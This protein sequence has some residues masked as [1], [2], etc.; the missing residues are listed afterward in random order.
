MW[1]HSARVL[2]K[3]FRSSLQNHGFVGDHS[4]LCISLWLICCK[5]FQHFLGG[6]IRKEQ[7]TFA[8]QML[9]GGSLFQ[10]RVPWPKGGGSACIRLLDLCP[11]R[12][13]RPCSFPRRICVDDYQ[14][15]KS[16]LARSEVG[17]DFTEWGR[18][19]VFVVE[20]IAVG[21]FVA[22]FMEF[23]DV[24]FLLFLALLLNLS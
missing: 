19:H 7:S 22:G 2:R 8:F 21:K 14:G 1:L 9:F 24:Y 18:D 16:V 10:K 3:F 12:P 5:I 17:L 23:L 20:H 4:S 6:L 15:K 13:G 11:K